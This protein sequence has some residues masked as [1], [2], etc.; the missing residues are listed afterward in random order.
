MHCRSSPLQA[1]ALRTLLEF[2]F[3]LHEMKTR[4][5]L[6]QTQK[7]KYLEKGRKLLHIRKGISN[8]PQLFVS[9]KNIL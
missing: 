1:G 9:V 7:V 8:Y 4:R 3:S 6:L 5:I 2:M